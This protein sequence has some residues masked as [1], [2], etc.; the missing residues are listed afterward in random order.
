M[1]TTGSDLDCLSDPKVVRVAGRGPALVEKGH[2]EWS[3]GRVKINT[4]RWFEDI[5]ENVWSFHIGGY[6]VCEKWLKDRRGR[7]LT[8]ADILHY[9]RI[10][11]AIGETIRL[12]AEI[13]RVIDAHGGW[14]GAFEG[15]SD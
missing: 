5:P 7:M 2:L 3:N 4:E 10:V 13:D 14:P 11:V 12:M 8:D 15:M 6:P 9:R 1:E